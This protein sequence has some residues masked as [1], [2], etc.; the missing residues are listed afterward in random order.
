ME[1]RFAILLL[2]TCILNILRSPFLEVD[3]MPVLQFPRRTFPNGQKFIKYPLQNLL[4][5][6]AE[7]SKYSLLLSR[8]ILLDDALFFT[9]AYWLCPASIH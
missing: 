7:L 9:G 8:V 6:V 1:R 5:Y 3:V 2:L 4:W